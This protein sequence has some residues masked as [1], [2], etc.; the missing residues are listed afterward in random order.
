MA[1]ATTLRTLLVL[2]LALALSY[3]CA[4][5]KHHVE[6]FVTCLEVGMSLDQVKDRCVPRLE[7]HALYLE[8]NFTSHNDITLACQTSG[9]LCRPANL[10]QVLKPSY[11]PPFTKEHPG[12]LEP[13]QMV[14]VDAIPLLGSFPHVKVF[15]NRG[16][17]RVIG[18]VAYGL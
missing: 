18:W 4:T 16:T 11:D 14:V 8:G 17:N 13:N 5:T 6:N 2:V 1:S 12:I 10:S 3:G 9:V 15:Y 7:R